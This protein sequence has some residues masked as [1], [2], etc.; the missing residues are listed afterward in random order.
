MDKWGWRSVETRLE[1]KRLNIL[2]HQSLETQ[3]HQS[4][5]LKHKRA[6]RIF[7]LTSVF[8]GKTRECQRLRTKGQPLTRLQNSQATTKASNSLKS[9]RGTLLEIWKWRNGCADKGLVC[10]LEHLWTNCRQDSPR[11]ILTHRQCVARAVCSVHLTVQCAVHSVQRCEQNDT[12]DLAQFTHVILKMCY[13]TLRT[14]HSVLHMLSNTVL[15]C[16][17]CFVQYAVCNH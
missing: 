5:L 9:F 3:T 7:W 15:H 1:M 6:Q 13:Y 8:T 11:P 10:W 17:M 12:A 16:K 4:S 14:T 2:T